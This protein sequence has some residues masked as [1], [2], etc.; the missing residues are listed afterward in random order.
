M[1][2]MLEKEVL[3]LLAPNK[4][5]LEW[6]KD[7]FL[8]RIT[9]LMGELS[10]HTPPSIFLGVTSN[11]GLDLEKAISTTDLSN[12]QAPEDFDAVDQPLNT[13]TDISYRAGTVSRGSE[14][15]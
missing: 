2:K 8:D 15:P 3:Y 7:N 9:E 4:F 6:I 14:Q 5:V 13:T 1:V 10:I 12:L 11:S